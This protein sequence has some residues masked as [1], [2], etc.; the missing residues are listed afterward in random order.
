LVASH[1]DGGTV[2]IKQ[3]QIFVFEFV[4]DGVFFKARFMVASVISR[5]STN[6]MAVLSF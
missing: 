2:A 3:E 4:A 1:D 6:R 5:L